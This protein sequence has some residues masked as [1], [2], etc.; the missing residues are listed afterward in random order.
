V[1]SREWEGERGELGAREGVGSQSKISQAMKECKLGV[2]VD[3]NLE[4]F[5]PTFFVPF[6]QLHHRLSF[7]SKISPESELG[8]SKA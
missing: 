1:G 6:F 4:P 3:E 8:V 2:G 5:Q 7:D